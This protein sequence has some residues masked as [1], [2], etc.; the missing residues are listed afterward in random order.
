VK[1]QPPDGRLN[2][3]GHRSTAALNMILDERSHAA[4]LSLDAR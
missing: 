4:L 3:F 1:L 2:P